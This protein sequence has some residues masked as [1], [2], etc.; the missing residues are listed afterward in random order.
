MEIIWIHENNEYNHGK[1][2]QNKSVVISYCIYSMV[3]NLL[4][5]LV[6]QSNPRFYTISCIRE[7]P[8]IIGI[9][10][11]FMISTDQHGGD[12]N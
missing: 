5:F 7:G 11:V 12:K 9:S 6:L 4:P 10:S 8:G 1:A 2:K 3:A